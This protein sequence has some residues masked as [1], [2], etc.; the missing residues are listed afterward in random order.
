MGGKSVAD[1]KV[2][3]TVTANDNKDFGGTVG[4]KAGSGVSSYAIS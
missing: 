2:R 3:F 4:V 1:E